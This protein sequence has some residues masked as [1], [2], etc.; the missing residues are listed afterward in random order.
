M[1]LISVKF[2]YNLILT[3]LKLQNAARYA[4][5]FNMVCKY[6]TALVF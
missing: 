1:L 3:I 5:L 6:L 4:Q 2:G